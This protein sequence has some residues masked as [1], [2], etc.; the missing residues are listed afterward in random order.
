MAIVIVIA[1]VIVIVIEIEIV[2]IIV[3]LIE[4]VI[5][6]DQRPMIWINDENF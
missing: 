1:T 6:I 3:K 5:V 4:T 2:I